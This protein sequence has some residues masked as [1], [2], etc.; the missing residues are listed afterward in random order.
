M[1]A[2]R[3]TD[4]QLSPRAAPRAGWRSLGS[5]GLF[6]L[7]VITVLPTTI[8]VVVGVIPMVVTLIVDDSEGRYLARTVAGMSTAAI[9]PFIATLWG[10]GN[11]M[12]VAIRLV[13]DVYTW[14]AVYAAVGLGWLM[15]LGFPSIVAELRK[16]SV[17]R[18]IAQ[19]KK[20]QQELIAEWG[21]S[22]ADTVSDPAETASEKANEAS[23]TSPQP[24]A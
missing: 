15:F 21:P 8:V 22:I 2:P 9:I 23:A 4:R 19:L 16:F 5:L 24:A 11:S 7:A 13:S 1:A 6:V 17:Q 12:A 3:H 10:A 18:R 14:F 20:Q